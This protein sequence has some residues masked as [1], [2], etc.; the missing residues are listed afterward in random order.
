MSM[1]ASR[2]CGQLLAEMDPV[3]LTS[4][5]AQQAALAKARSSL[6]TT[7]AQV[8][9]AQAR[10]EL[11]NANLRRQRDLARQTSSALQPWKGGSR[12]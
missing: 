11:A 6:N 4:A 1:G 3:D 12:K 2:G 7:A 5:Q 8:D 9:D 10:R